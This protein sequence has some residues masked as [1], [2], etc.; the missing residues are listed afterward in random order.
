MTDKVLIA[1]S[2]LSADF[3]E[4][5]SEVARLKDYGAD[6]VHLDVMDGSFVPNITFGAPMC[7][8][9]R[10][11][12]DLTFD[13]HLMVAEPAKWVESF[14]KAGADI[15]TIH[16]EA[17]VHAHRTLQLIRSY[18]K[19]AGI[20]LNPATSH[21]AVE[22]LLDDV[23]MVLVMSVN[24]G[25]GGQKFIDSSL[26][27]IEAVRE[28]IVKRGLKIDVEVDGGIN[29]TTS[30][31]AVSAGANVLVAGNAVYKA[32]DKKQMINKLRGN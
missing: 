2:I 26:R 3:T 32:E 21:N 30:R 13:A 1:P 18:G 20:A 6:W 17:D 23:D 15:I 22:Y 19:K 11:C 16:R 10:P 9:L 28:M 12:S 24:P 5:G 29:E 27:K 31:L 7:K 14:V 8:A 25:F 4:L